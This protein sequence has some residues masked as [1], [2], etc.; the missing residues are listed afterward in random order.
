MCCKNVQDSVL[1]SI[2]NLSLYHIDSTGRTKRRRGRRSVSSAKK[3]LTSIKNKIGQKKY[4]ELMAV[5]GSVTLS[6]AM[7]TT[8]SM[9]DEIQDATNLALG[10]VN[11]PRPIHQNID[12]ILFPFND[13]VSNRKKPFPHSLTLNST[14]RRRI[15]SRGRGG[16]DLMMDRGFA[17][18]FQES[19]SLLI[20]IIC[21]STRFILLFMGNFSK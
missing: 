19:C 17:A 11:T 8:G 21:L 9:H 3:T 18:L 20:S 16:H 5:H 6:F 4:D 15:R 10:I 14:L 12:Y 7:D 1:E 13:Q 2:S